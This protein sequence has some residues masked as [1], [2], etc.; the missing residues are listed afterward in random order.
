MTPTRT[1]AEGPTRA[2]IMGAGGRDFHNFNMVFRD[3]PDY[4]VVG[5]TATQIPGISGRRYPASLAGKLY[6]DGIPIFPEEEMESLITGKNVDYVY[7]SYSDVSHLEVMHQASRALA[8]GASFALLGPDQTMLTARTPVIAV[9]AVRT[10]A[11]KSP[12]SQWIVRWLQER[13]HRVSVLRHPMPYG[14]LARQAVQR[15]ASF[16][17]LDDAGVTVEEREEYEP[18]IRMGVPIWAGVDYASILARAEEEA[19]VILWDGGNND[20][21]FL[22]PD[23]HLVIVDPHRPGHELAYHPGEVNFRMADA[24]LLTKV[25]SAPPQQIEQVRQNIQALRPAAPIVMADLDITVQRPELIKGQQVAIVG[26]G[27][28]LT[29]GGMA[30]GAGTIAAKNHNAA[31]ILDP[32][33]YLTGSL[34]NTFESFPHLDREIPAMGY[35]PSQVRELEEVLKRMPVDVVIDATP[36]DLSRLINID[37]PVVNVDYQLRDLEGTLVSILLQF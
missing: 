30:F 17:D 33:P 31:A 22:R 24:Y 27:P 20:F 2:L 4:Q 11:G 12:A 21:P 16:T 19:G 32:R 14:D 25:G 13:G 1:G 37:K 23:L 29:H 36:V 10:G 6:P 7:F 28:T 34:A 3:N 9:C 35:D 5:F 15:F 26:D 8:T 18:Y